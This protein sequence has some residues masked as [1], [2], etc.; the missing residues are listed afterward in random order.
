M[1]DLSNIGIDP[2]VKPSAGEFEIVPPGKYQAVIVNDSLVQT[3]SGTGQMLVLTVQITEKGEFLGTELVDRINIINQSEKA[4]A[5]GQSRLR[6]ICDLCRVPFP[7][8]NT[9][10]LYGKPVLITVKVEEFE[11]NNTGGMLKSN[12]ISRYDAVIKQSTSTPQT[13]NTSNW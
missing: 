6:H 1:A 7:P 8:H 11:S 5:I 10:L 2:N 3:K 4:Q 13:K 12:K 9:R